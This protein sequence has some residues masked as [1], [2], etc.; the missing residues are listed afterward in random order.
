MG[1]KE[2]MTAEEK[3]SGHATEQFARSAPGSEGGRGISSPT[4]GSSDR[5]DAEGGEPPEP[6]ES[7]IVK[8]KSNI[9]NN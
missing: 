6:A 5:G 2:T 8:S 9:T 7:A 3:N 4:G 1:E